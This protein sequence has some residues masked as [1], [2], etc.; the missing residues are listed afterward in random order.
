MDPKAIFVMLAAIGGAIWYMGARDKPALT[1]EKVAA[2]GLTGQMTAATPTGKP[3]KRKKDYDG[4]NPEV[5][6]QSTLQGDLYLSPALVRPTGAHAIVTQAVSGLTPAAATALPSALVPVAAPADCVWRAPRP[7]DQVAGVYAMAGG[8][9]TPV[10]AYSDAR[11]ARAALKGL[12]EQKKTRG[13][14][15]ASNEDIPELPPGT[16][17][18]LVDVV[19]NLPGAPVFL[20]LQDRAGGIL[21][22]LLPAPGTQLG[23]VTLLSGGASGVANLP[24]GV[25][26]Q[27]QNLTPDTSCAK[28]MHPVEP[29]PE[30]ATPRSTFRFSGDA[31]RNHQTKR[32]VDFGKWFE[33]AFG[34]ASGTNTVV[35]AGLSHALLGDVPA[36]P[37]PHVG[38]GGGVVHLIPA[39]LTYAASPADHAAWV[40][41]RAVLMLTTAF[42]VTPGTDLGAVLRAQSTERVPG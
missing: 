37:L 13:A 25:P 27:G 39:D 30:T 4:T 17:L 42:G 11:I 22:N 6:K 24:A 28:G 29:P 23:A 10:H 7:G 34:Y 41:A 26:V 31:V 15:V 36:A 5:L 9:E 35:A 16:A 14:R 1:P 18:R 33:G 12:L 32:Y 40:R 20:T 8:P 19:V 3:A 2:V 38:P 21:W